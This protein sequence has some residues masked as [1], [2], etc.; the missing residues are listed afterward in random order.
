MKKHW[1]KPGFDFIF[2]LSLIVVMGL[3]L[4]VFSQGTKNMEIKINNGDTVINGKNIKELSPGER[5]QALKDI[6][7]LGQISGPGNGRRHMLI[8]K[9]GMADTGADKIV[10]EK[11]RFKNDDMAE[12]PGFG[13]D[14]TGH[15]FKF[16]IRKL[17][18]N[19]STFTFNYR[20]N[21]DRGE[22]MEE[23]DMDFDSRMR[24]PRMN[25]FMR[26]RNFQS[27]EYNNTGTD[28]ISTHIRFRVTDPSPE[29]IKTIT[30]SEKAELEI[31]DL[32][33]VPEFSSGKTM[34]MF[35][36]PAKTIAEVKFMDNEGKMIWSDKAVNGKFNKSF[37]LGLNGIY[38]LQVK[39]AGKVVL[40]RI[41]KED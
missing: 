24:G 37:A 27:F 40:K 30:G 31:K 9:R 26:H 16:R 35:N 14:S 21:G 5:Q 12:E 25:Y 6:D 11:R 39:Q 32:N 33:L 28:G 17:N 1:I 20:M 29:K 2:A 15:T 19:D 7:N 34:L 4:L 41:M 23:R 10:I 36:L 13:K 38:Y 18:G 8:R 3:P 22:R